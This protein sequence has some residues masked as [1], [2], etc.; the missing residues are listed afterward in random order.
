M[1]TEHLGEVLAHTHWSVVR[2]GQEILGHFSRSTDVYFVIEGSLRATHFT[3]AGKEV[4]YRVITAGDCF[5]E[6]SAIDGQPRSAS[7]IA[8]NE[9]LIA[10]MSA[11]AFQNTMRSNP[12]VMENL[13]NGMVKTVRA[14]SE[15]TFE[16]ISLPV[17]ARVHVELM[18]LAH[19]HGSGAKRIT[20]RPAPT[21]EVMAMQIGTHREAVT[22]ELGVLAKMG[23]IRLKRGVIV[24]L[25][26]QKLSE[27]VYNSTGQ[28]FEN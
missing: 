10:Q 23:V 26:H 18:R 4:V 20:I 12:L 17:R 7:I 22:R 9:A 2:T 14:L 24:I 3:A 15:R 25:S 19:S 8:Q 1:S 5:G 16:L 28:I 27:I 13:L 21:H 6:L 11:E